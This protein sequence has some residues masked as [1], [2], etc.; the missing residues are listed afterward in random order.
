MK[1]P[2][3]VEEVLYERGRSWN[4]RDSNYTLIAGSMQRKDAEFIAT[5]VNEYQSTAQISEEGPV[6]VSPLVSYWDRALP[7]AAGCLEE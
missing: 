2:L 1:L 3:R 4:L 5:V 6:I 7:D